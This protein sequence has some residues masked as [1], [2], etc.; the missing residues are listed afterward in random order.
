[1]N[2]ISKIEINACFRL[3]EYSFSD[4]IKSSA[5]YARVTIRQPRVK[6]GIPS[7]QKIHEFDPTLTD[8]DLNVDAAATRRVGEG[9][10]RGG[11]INVDETAT[12]P[13]F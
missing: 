12:Q 4:D 9:W 1:M 7:R 3:L 13:H 6:E 2:H 11:G 10:R 5:S 8:K